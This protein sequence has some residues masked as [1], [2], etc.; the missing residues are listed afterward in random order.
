MADDGAVLLTLKPH[1]LANALEKV[2]E[3]QISEQ[4]RPSFAEALFNV[5][6]AHGGFNWDDPFAEWLANGLSPSVRSIFRK[7]VR[8]HPAIGVRIGRLRKLEQIE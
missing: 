3:L 2:H 1:A 7:L 5:V 4:Q 6:N 8:S